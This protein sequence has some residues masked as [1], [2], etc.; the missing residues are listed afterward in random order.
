MFDIL[1][2]AGLHL[3]A[4]IT[5]HVIALAALH[6][7]KTVFIH[8]QAN[9]LLQKLSVDRA[10]LSF[11]LLSFFVLTRVGRHSFSGFTFACM[12]YIAR[13]SFSCFTLF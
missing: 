3:R 10:I 8:F 9:I 12:L 13:H 4:C 1:A 7:S 5:L 2:L 11:T 6:C